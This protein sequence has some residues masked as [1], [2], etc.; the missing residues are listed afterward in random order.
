MSS[1]D[2]DK[3]EIMAVCRWPGRP[4]LL[5]SFAGLAVVGAA[6]FVAGAMGESPLR[7]W[8]AYLVNLVF[9]T[10]LAAGAVLFSAILSITH[11]TWG[12]PLKRL[13]EAYGTF[14]LLA[15]LL[16]AVLYA[17]RGQVFPWLTHPVP[18]KAAW[19]N[20]PFLFWRDGVG[21]LLLGAGALALIYLSVRREIGAAGSP[22]PVVG[23]GGREEPVAVVCANLYAILYV[24]VLTLLAFDL[25]MSLA[26]HW[27]S[28]L[29]GAY[30]FVGSFYTSLAALMLLA[31]LAVKKEGVGR[32]LKA[33]HFHNLGKLQLGFA[34][35]TGD[36][37]FTQFLV[38][39]YGNL[40][41]E[42]EFV[43][44]RTQ[45]LPW[46]ALSWTV[47]TVCF[48]LPFLVL[49][50]R[51][52]K[53]QPWAMFTLSGL[54]LVGMWIEK[55]LLVAPSL[56]PGPGLP[57]GLT[58]FLISLGF[59]GIMALGITIFL[60]RFPWLPFADPLLKVEAA[61]RTD[62]EVVG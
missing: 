1:L 13:A 25:I 30:Y 54:I 19:L 36:F 16:F 22:P 8:Q 44:L 2:K 24:L 9:W 41:E 4:C 43:I 50:S 18:E 14:L 6:A 42:T 38:I 40:P 7:A 59:F 37:F 31:A 20:A 32:Y 17:G 56:W 45:V 33:P 57:L 27:H 39:W 15:P 53:M 34:L 47:L 60:Q 52:L 3:G 62:Q 49:L 29:F 48:I 61:D 58:E 21:L 11:A 26:P 23:A 51:R 12:R 46:Q 10:G 5:P 28:T 35:L 55:F